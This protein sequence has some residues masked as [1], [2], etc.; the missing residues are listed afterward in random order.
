MFPM[1]H[2]N[3]FI[4]DEQAVT[5]IEYGLLAGLIAVTIIG[6]LSATGASVTE[7][8][9]YWCEAVVNALAGAL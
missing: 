4:A 6:G 9:S 3:A 5:A 7:I 8:Y 1:R 2:F